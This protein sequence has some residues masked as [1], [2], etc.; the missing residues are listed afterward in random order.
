MARPTRTE[1]DAEIVDRAAA[2][3]ARHGY[4]NTSLQRIADAVGYSKAGLLHHFP[5]KEAI[6][7]AAV[8][9]SRDQAIAL[10][11]RVEDVPAGAGRDRT[12][13]EAAVDATFA[14]PGVSAL[15]LSLIGGDQP[16]DPDL[17]EIGLMWLR[18]LGID[19]EGTDDERMIRVV[20]AA[21]GLTVSALGAV[22]LGMTRE[23]RGLIVAAAMGTLGHGGTDAG[24]AR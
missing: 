7:R 23:W 18:A 5:T 3:F 1:I 4:A 21:A 11:A 17:A 8:A 15:G 9:A 13:M 19:P 20:S 10:L 16:D 12:V 6:Y 22:R 14:W 24:S 2:L